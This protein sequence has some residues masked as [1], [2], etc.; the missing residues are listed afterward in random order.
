[1]TSTTAADGGLNEATFQSTIPKVFF[2][3][4]AALGPK[5]IIWAVVHGHDAAVSIDQFLHADDLSER[6]LPQVSISS[7]KMGIHEWSN[8]NDISNDHLFKVPLK[9]LKIALANIKVEVELGFDE[10]LALAEAEPCLNCD[11]QTVFT[12]NLSAVHRPHGCQLAE[13][14]AQGSKASTSAT[15]VA[16]EYKQHKRCLLRHRG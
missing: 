8:D 1:M 13:G 3:G 16:A 2:G 7:Q 9:D 10:K 5:N 11:I 12:D 6:P 15:V 14:C 4:D